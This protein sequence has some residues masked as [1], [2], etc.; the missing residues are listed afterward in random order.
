MVSKVNINGRIIKVAPQYSEGV[1]Q[2]YRAYET[3]NGEWTFTTLAFHPEYYGPLG[4]DKNRAI[5]DTAE[6]YYYWNCS[7]AGNTLRDF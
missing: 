2:G 7:E 1:L 4:F 3:E 5:R 6:N